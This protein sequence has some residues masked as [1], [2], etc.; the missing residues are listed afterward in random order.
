SQTMGKLFE[1][2]EGGNTMLALAGDGMVAFS[3]TLK[4]MGDRGNATKKGFDIMAD[5]L[6]FQGDR[7]KALFSALKIRVAEFLEHG[8]ARALGFLNKLLDA[9]VN[10]PG[11]VMGV[12]VRLAMGAAGFVALVGGVASSIAAFKI[13]SATLST[14]GGGIL[15]SVLVA[16]GPAIA[17]IAGLSLA[18][19]AVRQAYDSNMGGFGDRVDALYG[20]IRIG[21][22]ALTQLFSQGGFS[23]EVRDEFNK[24]SNG[25]INFAIQVWLAFNRVKNFIG[26][27]FD[28]FEAAVDKMQPTIDDLMRAVDNLFGQ[29]GKLSLNT[30]EAGQAFDAAGGSGKK[31]GGVLAKVA[32]LVIKGVTAFI[33]LAAAIVPV[34]TSIG[35]LI[36]KVG[37]LDNILWAA[38][39]GLVAYATYMGVSA[40]AS[41]ASF[42]AANWGA[43][44]SVAA[45]VAKLVAMNGLSIASWASSAATGMKTLMGS[46]SAALGPI[47]AITAALVAW[48]VAYDQY[49][50]LQKEL[51]G[52]KGVNGERREWL[53]LKT[54]L[55]LMSE[56][57]RLIRT[58]MRSRQ[59]DKYLMET[60]GSADMVPAELR[61]GL[62]PTET[63]SASNT[64]AVASI[65]PNASGVDPA[66]IS[67]IAS[68]AVSAAASKMPPAQVTVK[69]EIDGQVLMSFVAKATDSNS[70]SSYAPSSVSED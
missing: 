23:G 22:L 27:V 45:L 56:D 70:S 17:A 10:L 35:D 38:K 31:V 59:T 3:E 34:A 25:A 7:A 9:F 2:V 46:A 24:G 28:G 15:G 55:G 5:T 12:I 50:K 66:A 53:Q 13:L 1:S 64:P 4:T 43:V 20:Q 33:D 58:G 54:S 65:S 67:S 14:F 63:P 21:F 41:V 29:F 8:A 26:G 18:F 37:G 6:S 51:D 52:F 60:Y 40:V 19:Y 68:E 49:R 48:Y 62:L 16:L 11:P 32:E 36:G 44:A 61:S 57:E 69:G 30:E 39:V 47:A 42:V